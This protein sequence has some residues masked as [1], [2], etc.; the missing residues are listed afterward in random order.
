MTGRNLTGRELK[1]CVCGFSPPADPNPD[2]ERCR[3]VCENARLAE[4]H[5]R[6]L[7]AAVSYRDD[8]LG[9]EYWDWRIGRRAGSAGTYAQAREA[10]RQ[11]ALDGP[12]PLP[13]WKRLF[14]PAR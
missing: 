12:P 2:C 5:D 14:R 4:A 9:G 10:V 11:A 3:L 1:A 6:L 13:W 7:A 8:W